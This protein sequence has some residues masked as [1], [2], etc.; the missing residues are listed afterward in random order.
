MW[1]INWLLSLQ[2]IKVDIFFILIVLKGRSA[3]ILKKKARVK[4]SPTSVHFLWYLD[5]YMRRGYVTN[6][7]DAITPFPQASLSI[8][9]LCM[10][11]LRLSIY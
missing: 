7:L 10:K 2:Y 5:N 11:L 6:R 8:K 9:A 1:N 3:P 4:K